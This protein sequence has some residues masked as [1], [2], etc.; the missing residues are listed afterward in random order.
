MPVRRARWLCGDDDGLHTVDW[1]GTVRHGNERKDPEVQ[2][3]VPQSEA[4]VW[5]PHGKLH[6][7]VV[8]QCNLELDPRNQWNSKKIDSAQTDSNVVEMLLG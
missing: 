7:T 6:L 5:V 4:A 2:V 8:R 3:G 1:G